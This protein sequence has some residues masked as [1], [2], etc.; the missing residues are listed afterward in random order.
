MSESKNAADYFVEEL[1]KENNEIEKDKKDKQ[2]ENPN[3]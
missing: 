2:I 3:G 1:L